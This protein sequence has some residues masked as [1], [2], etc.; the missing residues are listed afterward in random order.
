MHHSVNSEYF[1]TV[2]LWVMLLCFLMLFC[3]F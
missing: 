2:R 3:V 1:W